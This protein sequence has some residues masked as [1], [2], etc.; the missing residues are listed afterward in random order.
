[1]AL[2]ISA[3]L[4]IGVS[5]VG[6]YRARKHLCLTRLLRPKLVNELR[7]EIGEILSDVMR[8]TKLTKEILQDCRREMLTLGNLSELWITNWC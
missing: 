7:E 4:T 5:T 8:K 2:N 1:M 3:V 6:I